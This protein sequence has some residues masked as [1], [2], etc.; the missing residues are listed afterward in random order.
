M[1]TST[2]K[3]HGYTEISENV[4]WVIGV[5]TLVLKLAKERTLREV[6]VTTRLNVTVVGH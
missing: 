2:F 6:F 1:K 4:L 3:P 5:T